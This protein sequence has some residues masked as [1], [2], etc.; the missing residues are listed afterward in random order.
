MP[1]FPKIVLYN[2]KAVFWT[3]PLALIAVGSA[4]DRQRYRVV[5]VDGR[6]EPRSRLLEE[7]QDAACLGITVLTG[8]PLRDALAVSRAA[9]QA[10]PDLPVVWGGWHPSLFPAMVAA[11][12]SVTAAVTGQ[13]EETFP[14]ILERLAAG[15]S[16]AGVAGCAFSQAGRPQ[17]NFPRPMRDINAF[18][19]H[20][21]GL[22]DVERYFDRKGQ[23]QLDYISSQGCRFRC[24]FCADPAV[25]NR[26]WYGYTPERMLAEIGDL[27]RRHRFNDLSFQDETYF[28]HQKRVAAVAEGFLRQGFE[29]SWFGT[30]RADQGRRLDDE[31]LALCARS[32][33]RRVMIGLEAGA[34]ETV[35]WIQKDIKIEDMWL[36]AEKLIRQRIGA[37]INVIVGFPGERPESVAETLRVARQLRAMS[38]TFELA[39]FYF[40]PYPGNPIADRLQAE[41]YRFPQ[42]LEEWADFDYIGSGNEWL[43][44]AQQREIE[45]F[46]FYQRFAYSGNRSLARLPLRLLSRWRLERRVYAFP[47]ER[48]LVERLRPAQALS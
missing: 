5:I 32:G 16:L 48:R 39:V 42:T 36:T 7:I 19:R 31:V 33:L 20:D 40:K 28:T 9:R 37:I 25:F 44:P 12:G 22:I 30:L 35:D 26:G 21:Y 13:G 45:A 24:N 38:P 17:L 10:R 29:F 34:Q 23:R 1:S 41:A 4:L 43:S 15:A 8:A 6:L 3:M 27:W 14:E 46:K 11:E 18:P 2:P 47:L